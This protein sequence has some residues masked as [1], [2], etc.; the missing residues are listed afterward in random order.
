VKSRHIL[1]IVLINFIVFFAL[2]SI[3]EIAHSAASILVGCTY[4]KSILMDSNFVGPYTEMYCSG[5]NTLF[6]FLSGLIITASF[7][8]LFI[9]L[10]SPTRN[11]FFVSLGLSVVFSSL[12]VGIA[13]LQAMV[14]PMIGLG[15]FTTLAGEYLIASYYARNDFPLDLLEIEAEIS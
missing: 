4:Q 11:L 7:S 9:F 1:N 12:D 6:V 15:F 14:Y 2:I 8:G 5:A 3:H 13:G 10:R